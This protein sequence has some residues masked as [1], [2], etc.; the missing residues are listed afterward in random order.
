M[1]AVSHLVI[2][3]PELS[4]SDRDRLQEYRSTRDPLYYRLVEPHFTLVFP[5]PDGDPTAFSSEVRARLGDAG[6]IDFALRCALI[7]RDAF[8]NMYHVFLVPDE[9]FSELVKLH[10]R[11]YA[12]RFRPHHRFDI[13]FIP[14]I[15]VANDPDPEVCKR[16]TDEWNAEPLEIRGSIKALTLIE[17]D[18]IAIRELERIPLPLR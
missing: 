7:N 12:G 16:W 13:D 3:Y 2:A 14:H 15:G 11:L 1:A 9:G 6:P 17:Y 4:G 10:D 8:S 18:G 5:I